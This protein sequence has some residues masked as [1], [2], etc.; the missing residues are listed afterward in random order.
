M[1]YTMQCFTAVLNNNILSILIHTT[2][3]VHSTKNISEPYIEPFTKQF[4]VSVSVSVSKPHLLSPTSGY[5]SV[6]PIFPE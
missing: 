1:L 6:R 3:Y 4:I 2:T 5:G